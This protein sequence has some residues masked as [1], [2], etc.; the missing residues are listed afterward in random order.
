MFRKFKREKRRVVFV[1]ARMRAGDEWPEIGIGNISPGGFMAKSSS[2][3]DVGE[4]VEVRHRGLAITGRV[5][6][7]SGRRFGVE[8]SQPIDTESLLASSELGGKASGV[9]E[10]QARKWLW[11]WRSK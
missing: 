9:A 11:H 5:A 2:P 1:T 3:P 8:A 4:K 10:P 7:V 6:W